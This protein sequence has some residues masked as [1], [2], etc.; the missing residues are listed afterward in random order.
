MDEEHFIHVTIKIHVYEDDKE[1]RKKINRR[2]HFRR[3]AIFD[4]RLMII[5]HK[6]CICFIRNNIYVEGKEA[7]K[8]YLDN[9]EQQSDEQ[10]GVQAIFYLEYSTR[11]RPQI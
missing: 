6:L 5:S 1:E 2:L 9:A 8:A 4:D 7:L 10:Q 11:Q 3:V